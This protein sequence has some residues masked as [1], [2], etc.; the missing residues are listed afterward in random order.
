MRQ[1]YISENV[2]LDRFFASPSESPSRQS[3]KVKY[4]RKPLMS[5]FNYTR[6]NN[7]LK[8]T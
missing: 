8:F 1:N 5:T 3:S 2:E 6:L 7:K 4:Y